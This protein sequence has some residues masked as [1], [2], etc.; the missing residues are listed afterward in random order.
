[1]PSGWSVDPENTLGD[2]EDD[3][4]DEDDTT[5]PAKCQELFDALD[6]TNEDE[7]VGAA[8]VTFTQ[9][10]FGP[11]LSV[12]ISSFEDDVDDASLGRALD[13]LGQCPGVHR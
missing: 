9:G 2:E 13:A 4:A 12:E 5:T 7:P 11:F 10:G 1:M 6:A 8:S 3:S